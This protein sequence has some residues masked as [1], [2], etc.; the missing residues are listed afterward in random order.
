MEIRDPCLLNTPPF[1][2]L[3]CYVSVAELPVHLYEERGL[4]RPDLL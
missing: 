3:L 1:A 2:S 4:E